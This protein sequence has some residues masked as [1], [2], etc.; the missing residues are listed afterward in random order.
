M[1]EIAKFQEIKKV[2]LTPK[3]KDPHIRFEREYPENA[4]DR[5]GSWPGHDIPIK[6]D[7]I[8]ERTHWEVVIK[9]GLTEKFKKVSAI[10]GD[11]KAREVLDALG[12]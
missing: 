11:E 6:D 2:V 12:V 10:V 8:F 3:V 4:Y 9:T 1:I 5:Y 7:V